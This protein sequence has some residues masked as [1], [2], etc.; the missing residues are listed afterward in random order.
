MDYNRLCRGCFHELPMAGMVCPHCGFNEKEY[1]R[2]RRPEMLPLNTILRGS[3][4]VGRCLGKGG[5]GITYIGWHINLESVVAI[6][7]FYP[8]GIVFR[9]TNNPYTQNGTAVSLTDSGFNKA[10]QK[11]LGSFIKE[12]RTL[13]KL[14]L[15]G[16]VLVH[17]VLRKTIPCIWSWTL[18]RDVI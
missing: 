1:E 8:A 7:E 9:D 4:I 13:G 5:F 14:R 16:V 18:F 12:A 17:D 11:A 2:N 3:Y 6:K 10:Y 15:P